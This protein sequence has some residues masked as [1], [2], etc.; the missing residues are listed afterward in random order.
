VAT[1]IVPALIGAVFTQATAA[2]PDVLVYHGF[3]VSDD[4][5]DFLMIGVDDPY[6]DGPAN[7]VI[8]KQAPITAG[9]SRPRDE[10]GDLWCTALSWNGNGDSEAALDAVAAI[11]AAVE[12]MLRADPKLGITSSGRLV[13]EIG[14]GSRWNHNQG[15]DGALWFVSFPLAFVA[16]I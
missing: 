16:R 14:E 2:L 3:G 7:S 13:I 10:R 11:V 15:P 12:N 5:G 4:P 1:S 8:T 6:A 9:T